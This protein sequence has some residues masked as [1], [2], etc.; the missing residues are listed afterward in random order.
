MMWS[1]ELT[2]LPLNTFVPV[3]STLVLCTVAYYCA[4]W[5][6]GNGVVPVKNTRKKHNWKPVTTNSKVSKCF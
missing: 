5:V 2:L 4:K 3:I 6:A 1:T